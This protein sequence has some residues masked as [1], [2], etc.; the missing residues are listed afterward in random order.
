[1]PVRT[2]GPEPGTLYDMG[3]NYNSLDQPEEPGLFR[4][5]MD[6]E[7][8]SGGRRYPFRW[9]LGRD[10][11]L[12]IIDGEKY[13]MPGQTVL[14]TG[15]VRISEK[16]VKVSPYFWG[17]LIHESVW[18]VMDYVENTQITVEY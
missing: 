14:V 12:T 5:G 10:D 17:G 9:Q 7:G 4:V 6:F 8:N 18:I 2:K 13:L 1:V 15:S 11:E 16:T 3:E